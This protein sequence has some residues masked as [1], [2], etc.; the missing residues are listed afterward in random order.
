MDTTTSRWHRR[1]P[2]VR[3]CAVLV[4]AGLGTGSAHAAAPLNWLAVAALPDTPPQRPTAVDCPSASQC[5][6]TEDGGRVLATTAPL[7]AVPW[8]TAARIEPRGRLDAI[9][10]PAAP[11][12]FVVDALGNLAFGSAVDGAPAW[13]SWN[14]GLI[15]PLNGISCPSTSL[16]VAVDDAGR[17]LASTTPAAPL[18]WSLP[19]PVDSPNRLNAISCPTERLCVAVDN[20]GNALVSADPTT[21]GAW[22]VVPLAR[23]GS[24]SSVSCTSAG[25]CVVAARGG[26]VYA[27]A[28]V[29]SAPVTWSATTIDS[30]GVLSAVSCSAVG[31]CVA[32]DQSGNAFESD[33]P[34]STRPVWTRAAIDTAERPAGASCRPVVYCLVVDGGG[35]ALAAA[36]PAPSAVTG[37]AAVGSQTEAQIT[38]TVDPNDANVA[39][40]RFD[41]GPTM[42]YGRR[43]A[44]S[45]I[46][47]ATDG[48]QAVAASLRGLSAATAYHFRVTATTGVA[49]TSGADAVFITPPPLRA[50]PSLSGTPAVGSLLT[51]NANIPTAT[52]PV[53]PPTSV[54]YVWLADTTPIA[55]ATAATHLVGPADVGH[56]LRCQVSISG[57]GAVTTAASGFA[58]IPA[59]TAVVI[60]ETRVAAATH[61]ATWVRVPITCSPQAAGSCALTLR[62]TAVR[63]VHYRRRTITVGFATGVLAAGATRTLTAWLNEKGKCLLKKRRRIEVTVIVTGTVVGTLVATLREETVVLGPP[64]RPARHI[65]G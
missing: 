51:C 1:R 52:S 9:S 7:F 30:V 62:L 37:G 33:N 27:T 53:P 55:G 12:C 46:P 45:P 18:T 3:L 25:L 34:A 43:V 54:A 6:A 4:F 23:T 35:H 24:L 22:R 41:Y 48:S 13:T 28:A 47:R 11:R 64:R 65:A 59:Q 31:L 60:T 39:G 19:M 38:A 29:A 20:A 26:S 50:S 10:C 40:C 42:D 8:G 32:L 17:V 36:L 21:I 49:T 2:F 16:C 58:D 15:T 57:D 56:H 63:I 5:V 14:V 44:C 61:R